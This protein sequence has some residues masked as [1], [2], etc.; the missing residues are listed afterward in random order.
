MQDLL[1]SL[2]GRE[3]GEEHVERFR[4]LLGD[5]QGGRSPRQAPQWPQ[6]VKYRNSLRALYTGSDHNDDPGTPP[7]THDAGADRDRAPKPWLFTGR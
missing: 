1:S 5:C 4:C 3:V 2:R 7:Q 6:W